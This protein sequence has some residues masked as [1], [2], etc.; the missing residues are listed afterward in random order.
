MR[1]K[2]LL[3]S[4][5][6]VVAGVISSHAQGSNVYSA[7]V[8]GYVNVP[9]V[10][11]T[12]YLAATPLNAATNDLNNLLSALPVKSSV[13][14][15]N[16]AGFTPSTKIST[17]WSPDF[18]VNPGT[19]YFISSASAITNPFV[20]S[21]VVGFG[22]SVTNALPAGIFQL[23][24]S[25]IPFS[26]TLNDTNIGLTALPVKSQVQVWNGNGFTPSTKISTGWSPDLPVI[27]GQGFFV[28][29][30][31]ATNWVQTLPA[32]TP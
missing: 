9:L 23:V 31:T 10:A 5:A 11:N 7:N 12:F 8:V 32:A 30:A 29:S 6:A 22:G 27:A 25:P 21:I 19:G 4:A 28:T 1:T 3:L 14:I 2:T 17:G 13:Q 24:G 16:G 18:T 15:W 26:G 20:G